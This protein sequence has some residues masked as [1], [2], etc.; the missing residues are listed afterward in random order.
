MGRMGARGAESAFEEQ[1]KERRAEPKELREF[2]GTGDFASVV[3]VP[4]KGKKKIAGGAGSGDVS[5]AGAGLSFRLGW[6][7]VLRDGA[8]LPQPF[9]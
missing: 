1:E 2:R 5:E 7:R 9:R 4:A 3:C 6:R 8:G